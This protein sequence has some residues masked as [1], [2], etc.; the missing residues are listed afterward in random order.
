MKAEV[1]WA[2]ASV[3]EPADPPENVGESDGK[4]DDRDTSE[5]PGR[6]VNVFKMRSELGQS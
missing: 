5:Q 4:P 2:S 3:S 1:R 6:E